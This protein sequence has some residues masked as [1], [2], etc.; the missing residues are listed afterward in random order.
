M[1]MNSAPTFLDFTTK[2]CMNFFGVVK[3]DT[4]LTTS[5][6]KTLSLRI[7][8]VSRDIRPFRCVV[9]TSEMGKSNTILH[10][11]SSCNILASACLLLHAYTLH[12]R[13][14]EIVVLTHET[15]YDVPFS[16]FASH[17]G[18]YLP[19]LNEDAGT[20]LNI[21]SGRRSIR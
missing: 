12:D 8:S 4:V 18:I 21:L 6:S 13:I 10:S 7:N 3:V 1:F 14:T 2:K 9:S 17:C 5:A 16:I 15:Q 19:V 11:K 20:N